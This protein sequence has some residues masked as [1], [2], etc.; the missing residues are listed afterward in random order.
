MSGPEWSREKT[1]R[2]P[3]ILDSEV[4]ECSVCLSGMQGTGLCYSGFLLGGNETG[5]SRV[6]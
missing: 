1:L 3:E 6:G 5:D 4:V 2:E